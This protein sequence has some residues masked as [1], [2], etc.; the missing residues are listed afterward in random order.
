MT[1]LRICRSDRRV[2]LT[3]SLVTETRGVVFF[4]TFVRCPSPHNAVNL[5]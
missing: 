1:L 4:D 2:C 5:G 3:Q